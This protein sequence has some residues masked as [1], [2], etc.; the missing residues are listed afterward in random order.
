M[1]Q[2]K[3]VL[4]IP[5]NFKIVFLKLTKQFF[6]QYNNNFKFLFDDKITILI[7][8]NKMVIFY[9]NLFIKNSSI[10]LLKNLLNYNLYN[11]YINLKIIGLGFKFFEIKS[12]KNK[13]FLIKVGFSH[14]IFIKFINIKIFCFKNFEI[15]I[16]GNY[17]E[18]KKLGSFIRLIKKPECYKGKGIRYFNEKIKIKIGKRK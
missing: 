13:I 18:T 17:Y 8:N 3:Y 1:I 4:I 12:S 6:F 11:F 16:C 10:I 5:L 2:K 15:F 14:H 7:I 9:K